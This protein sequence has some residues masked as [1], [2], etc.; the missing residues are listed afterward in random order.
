MVEQMN[1]SSHEMKPVGPVNHLVLTDLCATVLS[2]L[3]L[4][5]PVRNSS[6]EC[7][8]LMTIMFYCDEEHFEALF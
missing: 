3:Q 6:S 2:V 5:M 1:N 4:L 8:A 7:M